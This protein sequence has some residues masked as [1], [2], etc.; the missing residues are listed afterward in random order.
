MTKKLDLLIEIG[1][2]ELPP[3]SLKKL[4]VSFSKEVS[5]LLNKERL[6]FNKINWYAT[7][8]RLSLIIDKLDMLQEYKKQQRKGPSLKISFDE[9]GEP[10]KAAQ[11]F[12]KSCNVSVDELLQ[13][14]TDKGEWLI[15]NSTGEGK[16]ACEI[17]PSLV[18]TALLRL[19]IA[20]RMS[21]GNSE[22]EFIRPIKWVLLLFGDKVISHDV[23]GVKSGGVTYGHRFHYPHK[24]KVD[25][26][27]DYISLLKNEAY[28]IADFDERLCIIEKQVAKLAKQYKGKVLIDPELLC[29]V[30]S[31]VEWPIAFVGKFNEKFLELPQEVLITTMKDHQKYFPMVDE[32]GKL[33]PFFIGVANIQSRKPEK[34]IQGNERVI[35]PRLNDAAFF[36]ERDLEYGLENKIESL[37]KIIY[38]RKLGTL[39]DKQ[40][41]IIEMTEFLSA[42]NSANIKYSKRAAELCLCDLLSEMVYEFPELQGTMG[43]YYAIENKEPKLV[44][45]AIEEFYKPRFSGDGLPFSKE[46]QC[47]A[48]SGRIDTIVGIFAIGKPPTGDKD[49][50]ALRRCAIGL[51]RII[52]ECEFDFNIKDLLKISA[53]LFPSQL[54]PHGVIDDVSLF[55]AE[56][57]K[58]YLLDEGFS[59]DVIDSI[60]AL[61]L[62]NFFDFYQRLI[63]VTEF[64][65]TQGSESLISANKRIS[66]ILKK[67]KNIAE[68]EVD[69]SLLS[70]TEEINLAKEVTRYHKILLPYIEEH[71]YKLSLAELVGLGEVITKFFDNTM[72]M[73]D[74]EKIRNNRLALLK[75]VQILFLQ[76][77]DFS[78]LQK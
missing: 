38:Q 2:E 1:C 40:E 49:P 24:I 46:G 25:N 59:L 8:R 27:N 29:E 22:I 28:V 14:R 43:K 66:N 4:A 18:E 70:E 57:L 16:Q 52:I 44:A 55:L 9:N 37:D 48:I 30:N 7:P 73:C 5:D 13:L 65:S 54:S 36:W 6:S 60:Q 15:Y 41:R 47:L 64:K 51:L 58:Y 23:M 72:I 26:V 71:N 12:A 31:L 45:N 17:I 32:A 61:N 20:K 74:D 75:R 77:A 33:L 62:S 69:N 34:I 68:Y 67:S 11:S 42:I 78:K 35:Q 3:R 50:F 56:R 19:P 10:T 63:A 39:K 53:D 76:I 21:W